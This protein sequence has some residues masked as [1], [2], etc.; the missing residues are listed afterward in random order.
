MYKLSKRRLKIKNKKEI[1]NIL[2]QLSSKFTIT[3]KKFGDGYFI[4]TFEPNSICWFYLK[5]F[6]EWKFGIWLNE[7]KKSYSIFG[8]AISLINKFKPS[9]STLSFN[10][11][12][13]FNNELPKILSN[14]GKW[15]DYNENALDQS[16]KDILDKEL[17]EI[18]IKN[19]K[20]YLNKI[21]KEFEDRKRNSFFKIKDMNTKDFHS[22]PRYIISEHTDKENYFQSN[23]SLIK[24]KKVFEKL[25][26]I[27]SYT[28]QYDLDNEKKIRHTDEYR[29]EN[30]CLIN[31]KDYNEKAKLYSYKEK[32][33]QEYLNN[34]KF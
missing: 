15:K 32:N 3:E 28:G 23:E 20:N 11:I 2:K 19:I 22:L 30:Q 9:A 33:F 16:E 26:S 27:L 12:T 1:N 34:I 10:N 24:T 18:D 8:E 4:L 29:F 6:P 25:C 13:D 5:E 21:E 14:E 31:K 7:E 17:S